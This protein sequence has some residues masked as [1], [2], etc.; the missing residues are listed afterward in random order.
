[1]VVEAADQEELA[2]KEVLEAQ[3]E[4][5]QEIIFLQALQHNQIQQQEG[6]V[7]LEDLDQAAEQ[8]HVI[9]ATVAAVLV[10]QGD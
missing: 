5:E 1:M 10:A 9:Q 8:I 2:H 4:E 3:A 6:M 7:M